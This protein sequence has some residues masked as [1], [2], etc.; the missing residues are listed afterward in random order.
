MCWEIFRKWI[1]ARIVVVCC[2]MSYRICTLLDSSVRL[3]LMLHIWRIGYSLR[4]RTFC[5]AR[6]TFNVIISLCYV[7]GYMN[8][9]LTDW[10]FVLC[11]QGEIRRREA[12]VKK[13]IQPIINLNDFTNAPKTEGLFDFHSHRISFF[14]LLWVQLVHS[15][16]SWNVR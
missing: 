7:E 10:S 13:E 16:Q 1:S 4:H 3:V 5:I 9:F 6:I 14:L 8:V 11:F 12:L 15:Y 2:S